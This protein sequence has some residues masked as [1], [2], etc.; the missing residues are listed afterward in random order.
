MAKQ[1]SNVDVIHR[2]QGDGDCSIDLFSVNAR[3]H[4]TCYDK[5]RNTRNYSARE[6]EGKKV[7]QL[8]AHAFDN[9]CEEIDGP[10]KAGKA[11]YVSSLTESYSQHLIHEGVDATDAHLYRNDKM[12]QRLKNHFGN[13]ILFWPQ[14]G[15]TSDL[16]CSSE[17]SASQLIS[18]CITLKRHMEDNFIPIPTSDESETDDSDELSSKHRTELANKLAYQVAQQIKTDIKTI[19]DYEEDAND[20]GAWSVNYEQADQ[21]IPPSV[22]NLLAFIL[23]D[24]VD[25]DCI[26]EERGKAKLPGREPA[27]TD[28]SRMSLHENV[29][30]VAQNILFAKTGKRTPQHVGLAVYIYH[31]T[32]SREII[33]VLNKLGLCISYND[34]HR[35]LTS[36]ALEVTEKCSVDNVFIPANIMPGNFTQYAIDNLDF[37]ECTLDGSSM[38]VT[39][40]V[41]FQNS[42]V[43]QTLEH[44]SF[45]TVPSKIHRRTSLD[46]LRISHD[47]PKRAGSI[48]KLTR[49]LRPTSEVDVDWLL[50]ED[51]N[52]LTDINLC[53]AIARACPTKLLEVDIDCPSWKVFHAAISQSNVSTTAIGYCPFLPNAPTN[54]DVVK[55]ALQICIRASEKLGMKHTIVTQDEAV[56]EISYTLR[57]N[58]PSHFPQLILRLGG[59]HLLMNYL[60]AIGKIMAGSGLKDMLVTSGIVHEGTANKILSGKGYYQS[61][62]AHMCAYESLLHMWW[63]AFEEFCLQK[64]I[65][66]NCFAEFNESVSEQ[67]DVPSGDTLNATATIPQIKHFLAQARPLM[68]AFNESRSEF[69]LHQFWLK[70]L[71]MMETL[72]LFIHA[73]REAIWSDHLSATSTM[74]KVIAAADHLKYT[75]VLVSYLEEMRN[76]PT[77]APEVEQE[78]QNGNFTVKRSSRKFNSIW[79][80]MALECSQNCDAK[81]RSGQAGLKGI[82]LKEKTQEKWFV[83][84][85]FSAS[86]TSALKTM[87][88]M[89]GSDHLHHEDNRAQERREHAQCEAVIDKFNAD[90]INPFRYEECKDIV[91]IESGLKATENVTKDLLLFEE[92]GKAAVESYI[93]TGKLTKVKLHT[94]SDLE[95]RV[96]PVKSKKQQ[97]T[98]LTEEL[99]VLKRALIERERDQSETTELVDILSYELRSYPPSLAEVDPETN[100]IHLRGGNKAALLETLKKT[101]GYEKWPESLPEPDVD[102]KSG[103]V[104]DVMGIIRTLKPNENELRE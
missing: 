10:L 66:L 13:S 46:T 26:D 75:K 49:D 28:S 96:K 82:T 17:L 99:Q 29:L 23:S 98:Y 15:N 11:M 37:S 8:Y 91:N 47:V 21:V 16:V 35:T 27:S 31:K 86:T 60:G 61:I 53:W 14:G 84:L 30:N 85:P 97:N 1:A 7:R 92:S 59:F 39:S 73:E 52:G 104:V 81:G 48:R 32:R 34:L 33:T 93:D 2:I 56:Y 6:A 9:L 71:A 4:K 50:K 38:H 76:L 103:I 64:D 100:D 67:V 63:C 89:D 95:K 72:L 69:N 65:Q 83:T 57:K 94:F 43:G 74:T 24:S 22:Y 20:T 51:E 77:Q 68:D 42:E 36:V 58:N 80:D 102:S 87:L 5:L 78:F 101:S 88:K 62:N 3:Y 44:G 18:A 54:P 25:F 40:M 19:P 45:G 12:K 79:T 90:M 70:Y 55:E 41:M